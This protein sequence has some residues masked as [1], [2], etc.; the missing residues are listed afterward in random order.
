MRKRDK[1]WFQTGPLSDPEYA[2]A[3][4]YYR[5]AASRAEKYM[6]WALK[7]LEELEDE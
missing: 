2:Y 4:D 3:E 6:M 1:I 7:K 5:A